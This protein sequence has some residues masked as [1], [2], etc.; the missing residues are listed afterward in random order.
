MI[1][2]ILS[3]IPKLLLTLFLELIGYF[4]VL[5][6]LGYRYALKKPLNEPLWRPFYWFDNQNGQYGDNPKSLWSVWYWLC[7]RN[8]LN[9]F[10][11]RVLGFVWKDSVKIVYMDERPPNYQTSDEHTSG[12]W[13]TEID[14]EGKT[15]WEYFLIKKWPKIN[16]VFRLRCGWKIGRIESNTPGESVQ[17]C[18]TITP[19]M[20]IS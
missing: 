4:I 15:Y 19:F 12:A 9:V 7:I 20:T 17:W 14:I 5:G 13:Y 10:Q 16:K 18:C 6:I 8:P 3:Q 2:K 1:N 11:Y